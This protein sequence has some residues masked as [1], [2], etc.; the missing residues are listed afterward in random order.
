MLAFV[1][2]NYHN[3]QDD[4]EVALT[5]QNEGNKNKKDR[6]KYYHCGEQGHLKRNCPKKHIPK[7]QLQNRSE[8][9]AAVVTDNKEKP[10]P[11]T[12]VAQ[13]VAEECS[14][15]GDF[16]FIAN[17]DDSNDHHS[18]DTSR[19]NKSDIPDFVFSME[20]KDIVPIV[21]NGKN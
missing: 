6:R 12:T 21:L 18:Q 8:E 14:S 16:G 10:E 20:S 2:N 13:L 3:D 11:P 4:E 1:E 19:D 9:A 15:N 5:T 17:V 7:E